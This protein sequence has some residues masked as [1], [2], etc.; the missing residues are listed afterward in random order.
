MGNFTEAYKLTNVFEGEYSN[1]SKDAGGETYRGI[2]RNYWKDWGGWDIID[3]LNKGQS[4]AQ[5]NLVLRDNSELATLVHEFY[6]TN[7]WDKARLDEITDQNICNEIYDTGVNFGMGKGVKFL[8]QAINLTRKD[9]Q[10][11]EDGAIG[12]K[13]IQATNSHPN[14]KLLYKTLNV[15]QGMAYINNVWKNPSQEKFFNGWLTRVSFL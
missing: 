13:T 12:I 10:L 11:D 8:Q 9:V 15:L 4:V 7:F 14:H 5:I 6:K 3:A 2:A 1:V